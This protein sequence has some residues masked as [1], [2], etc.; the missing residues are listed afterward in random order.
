[1]R[2]QKIIS[3]AEVRKALASYMES[4]GCECCQDTERH[5][6]NEE[7]LA[8]LLDVPKYKDGSGWDFNKFLP[9]SKRR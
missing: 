9:K 6:V 2:K 4:E 7:R 1:M 3:V 5:K 8:R